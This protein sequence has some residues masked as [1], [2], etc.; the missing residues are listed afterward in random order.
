MEGGKNGVA[1]QMTV[2]FGKR[3]ELIFPT[4]YSAIFQVFF[5]CKRVKIDGTVKFSSDVL[6]D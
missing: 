5:S 4:M 6:Q 2:R 1:V 3:R